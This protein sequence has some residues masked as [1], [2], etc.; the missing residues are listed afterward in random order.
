MVLAGEH[1][2]YDDSDEKE[3]AQVLLKPLPTSEAPPAPKKTSGDKGK[4]K[5]ALAMADKE[6]EEVEGK[7]FALLMKLLAQLLPKLTDVVEDEA[8]SH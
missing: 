4:R 1:E 5:K 7:E 6:K 8:T 2:L 3:K